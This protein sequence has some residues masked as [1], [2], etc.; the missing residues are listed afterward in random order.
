MKSQGSDKTRVKEIVSRVARIVALQTQGILCRPPS[1]QLRNFFC[2]NSL[3]AAGV[4][5]AE[6]LARSGGVTE[7]YGRSP[8]VCNA[9]AIRRR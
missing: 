2:D 3:P 8:I 1:T 7:D 4:V 5:V 6:P 9:E